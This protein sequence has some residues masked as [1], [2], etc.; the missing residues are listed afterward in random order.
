MADLRIPA[1]KTVS[2]CRFAKESVMPDFELLS[3]DFTRA[4]ARQRHR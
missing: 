4:F 2:A 3:A 1:E